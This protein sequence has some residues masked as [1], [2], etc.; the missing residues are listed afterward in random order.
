M[1]IKEINIRKKPEHKLNAQDT[2]TAVIKN[3][4][5]ISQTENGFLEWTQIFFIYLQ[6]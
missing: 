1:K 5:N 4:V 3:F 2:I 6:F